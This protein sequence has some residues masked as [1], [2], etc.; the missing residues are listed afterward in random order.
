MWSKIKNFP[1]NEKMVK[2]QKFGQK[3][4]HLVKNQ[5]FGYKFGSKSEMWPKTGSQKFCKK[6]A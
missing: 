6:D 5:K 1:K 2:N 4:E 3:I